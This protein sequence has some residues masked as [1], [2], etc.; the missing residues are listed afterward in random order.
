[1]IRN[2]NEVCWH[3][4]KDSVILDHWLITVKLCELLATV[5]YSGQEANPEK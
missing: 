2:C 4:F 1:M 3:T 5:A